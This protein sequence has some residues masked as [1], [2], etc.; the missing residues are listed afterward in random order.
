MTE[1]GYCG[2]DCKNCPRYVATINNDTEKLM[3]AALMWKRV[4]WRDTMGTVG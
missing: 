1:I 4:G 2:D 3:E